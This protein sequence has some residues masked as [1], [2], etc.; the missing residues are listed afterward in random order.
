MGLRIIG[1]NCLGLIRPS[2]NLNA[3]FIPGMPYK[4]IIGFF[5]SQS[6]AIGTACLDQAYLDNVGFSHFVSIG[7][8]LDVD[9]GDMIDVLGNDGTVKAILI[10]ME[11]LTN[12]RKFMSAARAV[13]QIKPI[14]VLKAGKSEAGARA[15][16]THIGAMVGEDAVYDAAFKRAGIVRCPPWRGCS[17]APN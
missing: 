10:Y 11:T 7:S 6:G 9:F 5:I 16:T 17:I 3:S 15:A 8:M 2:K 14:I 1:P 13:S 4:G 12:T